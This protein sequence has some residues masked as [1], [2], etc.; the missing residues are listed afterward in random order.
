M[1]TANN[2]VALNWTLNFPSNLN[3]TGYKFLIRWESENRKVCDDG[4]IIQKSVGKPVVC[5]M[6][7]NHG[8]IFSFFGGVILKIETLPLNCSWLTL[9]LLNY[10]RIEGLK[11]FLKE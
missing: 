10:L 8:Q 3:I 2:S 4:H 6:D 7:L 9:L 1:V 11:C 5:N